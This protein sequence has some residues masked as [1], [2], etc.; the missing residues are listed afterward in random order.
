MILPEIV[1]SC[2]YLLA[3]WLWLFFLCPSYY[4]PLSFILDYSLITKCLPFSYGILVHGGNLKCMCLL[5]HLNFYLFFF[6]Q[7][8]GPLNRLTIP[9][10][11]N[12]TESRKEKVEESNK[13]VS[14]AELNHQFLTKTP[15]RFRSMSKRFG[16]TG[17]Y[18]LRYTAASVLT[19]PV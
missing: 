6:F 13:F 18:V 16:S 8:K 14:I 17:M 2:Q 4:F 12:L 10:P 15:Q 19:E 11:F 5:F 7:T 9:Q 3:L 1:V